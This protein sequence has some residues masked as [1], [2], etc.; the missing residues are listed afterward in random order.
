MTHHQHDSEEEAEARKPRVV[1]KRISAR[2]AEPQTAPVPP[3][4]VRPRP[5][6]PR[7]A[8]PAPS[9][10]A[11][12]RE[13]PEAGS[14]ELWTPEQEAQARKMVQ[15]MAEVPSLEWVINVAVSLANAAGVKLN[16]R[17]LEDARLAIDALAGM[18]SSVGSRLQDAEAPLRQTLA[19]LQMAYSQLASQPP[20]QPE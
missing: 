9:G 4:E 18:M 14:D 7:A 16:S 1:D 12:T 13:G 11:P 10:P 8:P 15:E 5:P 2:G 17:H 20:P 6:E 3:Q 19:E